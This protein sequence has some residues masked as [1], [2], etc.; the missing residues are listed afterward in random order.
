MAEKKTERS[1]CRFAV[2]RA[3]DGKPILVVEL[4]QDTI[5]M[6]RQVLIGFELLGGMRI[7]D[8][9]KLAEMLNEH[10]LDLFVTS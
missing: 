9:K 6:L 5:P 1:N 10:V 4:F 3:S 8:G 2:E 7:E